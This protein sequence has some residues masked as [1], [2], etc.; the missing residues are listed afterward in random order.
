MTHTHQN[1][2]FAQ[3]HLRDVIVQIQKR[4]TSAVEQPNSRS[5]QLQ[6]D[7]AILVRPQFVAR[8]DR[9]IYSRIDPIL[10]ASWLK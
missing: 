5:V 2:A 3:A 7:S 10:R 8:S 1:R 4:K 6:F 9:S